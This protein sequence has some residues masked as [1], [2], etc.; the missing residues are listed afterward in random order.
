MKTAMWLH[1]MGSRQP[2][3]QA[4]AL[5]LAG[6]LLFALGTPAAGSPPKPWQG[7]PAG[8]SLRAPAYGALPYFAMDKGQQPPGFQSPSPEEKGRMQRQYREWQSLPPDQ[9]DTMRRRM[10]DWNRMPQQ[11]RD[12]YQQRYQQYQQLSPEERRQLE[13]NL[14]RWDRLS[15]Q[16]RD[17]IRQRFNK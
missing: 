11:N 3:R 13:N 2:W 16:E 14:Q 4:A 8:D 15:P 7:T 17:S 6:V 9:K 12:L 5:M 10:D 1:N